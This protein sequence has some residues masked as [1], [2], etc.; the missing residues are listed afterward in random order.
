MRSCSTSKL[1]LRLSPKSRSGGYG[2][3]D[4]AGLVKVGRDAFLIGYAYAAREN[5]CIVTFEVSAPRK[6]GANRKIPDICADLGIECCTLFALIDALD[7][8]T[9]WKP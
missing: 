4:E 2:A 6:L 7:F 8:T 5:R 9:N 3:L 1:T